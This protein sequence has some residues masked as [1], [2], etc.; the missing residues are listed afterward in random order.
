MNIK[1]LGTRDVYS[2]LVLRFR[3]PIRLVIQIFLGKKTMEDFS[4][5]KKDAD[6]MF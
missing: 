6:V 3:Q 4:A 1:W 2:A 5:N